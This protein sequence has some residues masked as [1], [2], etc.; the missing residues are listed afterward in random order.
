MA[1]TINT[2]I[3]TI[4]SVLQLIW[5]RKRPESY[6]RHRTKISMLHRA[7]NWAEWWLSERTPLGRFTHFVYP[8]SDSWSTLLT[9]ATQRSLIKAMAQLNHPLPVSHLLLV[10]AMSLLDAM[11]F[12][13]SFVRFVIPAF[14]LQS[15]TQQLCH[16]MHSAFTLPWS[17][18]DSMPE[19][20]AEM[21][22]CSPGYIEYV[23]VFAMCYQIVIL[24]PLGPTFLL[25]RASKAAFLTSL[26]PRKP[27]WAM[28]LLERYRPPSW[29]DILL[30]TWLC[31]SLPW[32]AVTLACR[33]LGAA[34]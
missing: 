29:S 25:E 19:A 9:F 34:G 6:L 12:G 7:R 32:M 33:L 8:P 15:K 13:P 5:M 11:L 1:G 3:H 4:L 20:S 23:A 10:S 2:C 14:Q 28:Q 21:L 26:G 17:L 27:Q 30:T 24:L 31:L 18:L 16:V 22:H